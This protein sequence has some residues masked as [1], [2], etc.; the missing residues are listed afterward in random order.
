MRRYEESNTQR[1]AV[2]W[3]RIQYPN[4]VLFSIPNGGAR[5]KIEAAVL[6]GEGV[7]SGCADLFLACSSGFDNGMFIEMKS[8]KGRQTE[9][10][11]L[12]EKKV[13]LFGYKYVVCR[14]LDEFINEVNEYLKN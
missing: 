3:F 11:K 13:C 12:F 2:K 10:Q 4:H 6:K 5:N 8:E 9:S 14:S 7:L 1:N